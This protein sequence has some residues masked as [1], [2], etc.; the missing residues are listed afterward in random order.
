MQGRSKVPTRFEQGVGRFSRRRGL[1]LFPI[2]IVP[3]DQCTGLKQRKQTYCDSS[4][5]HKSKMDLTRLKS[6]SS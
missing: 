3:S 1:Q 4:G 5:V 2:V 6:N